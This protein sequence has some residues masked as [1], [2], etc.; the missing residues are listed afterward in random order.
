MPINNFLLKNFEHTKFPAR[1]TLRR[2]R[3]RRSEYFSHATLTC[4]GL[5]CHIVLFL[6]FFFC[7]NFS[8]IQWNRSLM[9]F[10]LRVFFLLSFVRIASFEFN[11]KIVNHC[12]GIGRR[13][14]T[15]GT[16][17]I[18]DRNHL[19]WRWSS[20][21]IGRTAWSI[22][23]WVLLMLTWVFV[24]SCEIICYVFS[25]KI[26]LVVRHMP[27]IWFHRSRVW[28]PLR[29]Q[30][31]VTKQLNRWKLWPHSTALPIWRHTWFQHWTHWHLAT[32]SPRV[33]RPAHCLPYAM[34]VYRRPSKLN[35]ATISVNCAK[36]KRQ[37]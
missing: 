37:W 24:I 23:Q 36:M 15:N 34:N 6:F 13:A 22:H 21:C 10:H 32:G 25:F 9:I 19:R 20:T 2:V 31:C 16:Y 33:H 17:S 8:G 5:G 11:K 26:W 18:F 12:I 30:L 7:R 1:S 4:V 14:H 3:V 29:R 35:F 28:P 27:C